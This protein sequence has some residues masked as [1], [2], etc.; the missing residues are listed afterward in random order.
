MDAKE[1]REQFPEVVQEIERQ[2]I[3]D[4]IQNE[5]RELTNFAFYRTYWLAALTMPKSMRDEFIM[6][7]VNYAFTGIVPDLKPQAMSAFVAARPNIDNSVDAVLFGKKGGRPRGHREE[8]DDGKHEA[9]I[10]EIV[11]YLNAKTGKR[12]KATTADAR[13]HIV[14]RL[15]EGYTVDEFKR[16]VDNMVAEWQNDAKMSKYLRPSTLFGSKMD[17]YLNATKGE[18]CGNYGQYR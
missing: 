12:Y 13:R 16:V 8:K 15:N 9:E 7:I 18:G 3:E 5:R 1:L 17:S 14:A 11:T 4:Y 2:A 6:G 10:E